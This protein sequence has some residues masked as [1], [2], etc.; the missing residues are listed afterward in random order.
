VSCRAIST[1][2]A[3]ALRGPQGTVN[4][5]NADGGA[6]NVTTNM[7]KLDA[8]HMGVEGSYGSYNYQRE[9]GMVNLPLTK[10]LAFRAT[11]QHEAHDGWYYAPNY[12]GNDHIG[13]Q[14]AWTARGTFLWTP[15][16]RLTVTVW[17]ELYS[18]DIN[19]VG[20]QHDRPDR[21]VRATSNDYATPEQTR[22]RIAAQRRPMTWA[23]RRRSSAPATSTPSS[24]TAIRGL[25]LDRAGARILWR[26]GQHPRTLV[27]PQHRQRGIQRCL[28]A[29][30]RFDW[31]VGLFYQ[32][33]SGNENVFETQQGPA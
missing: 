24:T 5:Q 16:D 8:F 20:A 27:G 19:G 7:P 2:T 17:G 31:I 33:T 21:G 25:A 32:H 28:E 29:G 18:N 9:N 30:G 6:I 15:T 3:E 22:S 11:V 14:N 26:E 10:N 13:S 23:A 4:G 12:P 1:S